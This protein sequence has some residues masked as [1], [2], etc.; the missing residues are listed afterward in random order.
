[1]I[2]DVSDPSVPSASAKL[3]EKMPFV[4]A[5]QGWVCDRYTDAGMHGA[6]LLGRAAAARLGAPLAEL[7]EPEAASDLGWQTSLAKAMPYLREVAEMVDELMTHGRRPLIFANRCGASLATIAAALRHRPETKIIWCDAHGDFNTPE[8]TPTGYL[9]GMV[10]TALCGLWD[11]GLGAG[12]KPEQIILVGQRDLDP[13]EQ[14]LIDAYGVKLITAREGTIDPTELLDA[15]GGAPIWFHID[16]DVVDP[17]YLPA[18]YQVDLGLHPMAVRAMLSALM[19][20]SELVGFEL[21]EFEPPMNAELLQ[22][23]AIASIML[24]LEPVL[25]TCAL[26]KDAR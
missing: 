19:Q 24:M 6:A 11:S 18:E 3:I 21:T 8:S 20:T 4:L 16:T 5:L 23:R 14:A 1:M 12:L 7:G 15:V 22:A 25:E 10:L 26:V 13:A 17:L 9:G 2:I